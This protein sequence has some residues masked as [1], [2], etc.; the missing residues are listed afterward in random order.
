M[1]V[2]R[3]FLVE[4][5]SATTSTRTPLDVRPVGTAYRSAKEDMVQGNV[6]F[7]IGSLFKAFLTQ[8]TRL[9]GATPMSLEK[10]AQAFQPIAELRIRSLSS[11]VSLHLCSITYRRK[12][13]GWEMERSVLVVLIIINNSLHLKLLG[14]SFCI[15]GTGPLHLE[16]HLVSSCHQSLSHCCTTDKWGFF[17]AALRKTLFWV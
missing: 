1:I 11:V 5:T 2:E 13:G 3:E 12:G 16:P 17:L 6:V 10:R 4:L 14:A 9:V 8:R 7:Q 15:A